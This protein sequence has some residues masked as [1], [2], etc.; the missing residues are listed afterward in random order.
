MDRLLIYHYYYIKN[1]VFAFLGDGSKDDQLMQ[2][3]QHMS[4]REWI[5]LSQTYLDIPLL[6]YLPELSPP[7]SLS[8]VFN[9]FK[10]WKQTQPHLTVLDLR[11]II[12]QAIDDNLL[13]THILD[14]MNQDGQYISS[15]CNI[16]DI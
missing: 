5:V 8:D 16:M 15:I 9:T 11:K 3:A 14:I 7:L 1:Y 13:T 12:C 2:L 6:K 10:K 4:Y